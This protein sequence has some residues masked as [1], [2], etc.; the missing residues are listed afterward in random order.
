M[1]NILDA[2]AARQ[3]ITLKTLYQAASAALT[4]AENCDE[5]SP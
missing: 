3:L 2:Y 5:I 1:M 4:G